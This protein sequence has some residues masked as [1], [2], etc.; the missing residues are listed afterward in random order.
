MDQVLN[1]PRNPARAIGNPYWPVMGFATLAAACSVFNG[2]FQTEQ[3]FA[4]PNEVAKPL[5][6]PL[7]SPGCENI[8]QYNRLVVGILIISAMSFGYYYHQHKGRVEKQRLYNNIN[9]LRRSLLCEIPRA[10]MAERNVTSLQSELN[11]Y[12]QA[13]DH[14]QSNILT[15]ERTI[16]DQ[17]RLLARDNEIIR[18]LDGTIAAMHQDKKFRRDLFRLSNN[19]QASLAPTYI[20]RPPSP[21][22]FLSLYS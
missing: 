4:K 16:T 6:W 21:S 14:Q 22:T 2:I 17:T 11:F 10:N 18:D 15:L 5:F 8:S 13:V 7:P 9:Y 19:P 3:C 12:S 1:L 20:P